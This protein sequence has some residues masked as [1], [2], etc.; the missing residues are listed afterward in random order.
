MVR[1]FILP[2]AKVTLGGLA[3]LFGPACPPTGLTTGLVR[4]GGD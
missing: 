3:W 4:L 1:T 2:Q